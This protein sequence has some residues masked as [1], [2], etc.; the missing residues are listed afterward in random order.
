MLFCRSLQNETM[1]GSVPWAAGYEIMHVPDQ[2]GWEDDPNLFFAWLNSE[3]FDSP[4]SEDESDE[5][6]EVEDVSNVNVSQNNQTNQNNQANS[7]V[8]MNR[9]T[10]GKTVVAMLIFVVAVAIY[11]DRSLI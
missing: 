11:I 2:E 3:A 1:C 10:H 9:P 8:G 6:S 7:D 5:E 4:E